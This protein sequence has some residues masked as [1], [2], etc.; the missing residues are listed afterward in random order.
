M[1]RPLV[2]AH[3]GA[4]GERPENTMSA[5]ER[6]IE[7]SA[8]MI[9]TDLH[10]SRDGVIV[11]HHDAALERLGMEG[12]IRERTA[13]ELAALNAAPGASV[14]ERIP[15]LL[16]LFDSFAERIEFNL[17]LKGGVDEPYEGLEELVLAELEARK[18]MPRMLLSSFD[19]GVL[20]R[21]RK[22]ASTA[23]L[24]V[25]VSPRAPKGIL[26]RARRVKAEAI[27]PQCFLVDEELVRSAHEEG[28]AVYPYTANELPEM[29]RLLDCGVDG[30]ITNYPARLRE[31]VDGRESA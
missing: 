14:V 27:N 23:R 16:D 21:L 2:I 6:A 28:L 20:E 10:L 29:T 1:T 9:E 24:A 31:L 3:R 26:E 12:E 30:V 4:S 13:A 15:H 22:R 8:D 18:L 25:L 7:L 5:F 17:E 19:D 11:I